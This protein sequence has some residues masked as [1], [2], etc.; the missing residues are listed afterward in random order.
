MKPFLAALHVLFRDALFLGAVVAAL[1]LFGVL[2]WLFFGAAPAKT[3][4][5]KTF[6]HMHC[7]SCLEEFTYNP[8]VVG[9]KCPNCSAGAK[10][11]GTV[12]SLEE[13]AKEPGN[14]GTIILFSLLT[15][16]LLQGLVFVGARRFA[17]LREREEDYRNRRLIARC[18][19]CKRKVSFAATKAGTWTTCFQCKTAFQLSDIDASELAL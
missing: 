6:T 15:L 3:E 5:P 14:T 11:V 9:R 17:V 19:Y 1:A 16:V 2:S 13:I 4:K 18:P 8:A 7:P 12:G 10:Y